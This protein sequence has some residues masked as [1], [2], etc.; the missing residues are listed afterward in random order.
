VNLLRTSGDN[1]DIFILVPLPSDAVTFGGG[2]K[3]VRYWNIVAWMMFGGNRFLFEEKNI[4]NK[5][6]FFRKI[7]KILKGKNKS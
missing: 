1:S 7:N 5:K 6:K 2:S 4:N 3:C